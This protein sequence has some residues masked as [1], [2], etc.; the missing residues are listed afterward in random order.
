MF[1]CCK[2]V[3]VKILALRILHC[4]GSEMIYLFI[5][6]N[7]LITVSKNCFEKVIDIYV[8]CILYMIRFLHYPFE[9][10]ARLNN[11][12]E[13]SPYRKENTTLHHYKD[14]L[15]NAV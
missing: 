14:Q 1:V 5:F 8:T 13:F 9:A 15:V 11:I 2:P 7:S 10:E 6:L 12:Y 4:T 3:V